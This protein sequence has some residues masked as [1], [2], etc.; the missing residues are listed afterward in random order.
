MEPN[1]LTSGLQNKQCGD[2]GI[3]NLLWVGDVNCRHLK[4][5]FVEP[6][7]A[8]QFLDDLHHHPLQ[9]QSRQ[10]RQRRLTWKQTKPWE[11]R[12]VKSTRLSVGFVAGFVGLAEVE[13]QLV[14]ALLAQLLH[15]VEGALAEGLTH[16]V[17]EHKH[18]VRLL[19]CATEAEP[20]GA[21]PRLQ[22]LNPPPP[23]TP[24]FDAQTY[25]AK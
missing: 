6:W 24:P 10:R 21:A 7:T 8:T 19:S 17:E 16:R 25:L 4:T 5:T 9:V 2:K 18:Q 12:N 15:D 3:T 1:N 14:S 11:G 22:S 13:K 20:L 23:P